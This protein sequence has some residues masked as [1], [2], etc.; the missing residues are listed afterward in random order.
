MNPN[1]FVKIEYYAFPE[2]KNTLE[3]F[4][5]I[6][7]FKAEVEESY[8]SFI[9]GQGI[10]R[11]GGAYELM[12][13]FISNI[14]WSD[15]LLYIAADLGKKAITKSE[16]L[17]LDKYLFKPIQKAYKKLKNKNEILDCYS[18]Q[19]ELQDIRIFIYRTSHNSLMPNLEKILKTIENHAEQIRGAV[20]SNVS[21]IHIPVVIDLL[22]GRKIFRVPL[23]DMESLDLNEDNLFEYWGIKHHYNQSLKVYSLNSENIEDNQFPDFYLEE[24]FINKKFY[25]Q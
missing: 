22:E 7:I 6:E 5:D 16:N 15:L 13:H 21:E 2:N 9:R 25:K 8:N 17:L 20:D 19:V 18:F 3:D 24:E 12:I 14:H 23:G 4:Q 11:G 10:G 1:D